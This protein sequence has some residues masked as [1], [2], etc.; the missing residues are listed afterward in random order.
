MDSKEHNP[1]QD[2][3]G[4]EQLLAR[5]EEGDANAQLSLGEKY[6]DG[7]CVLKD[8][9][10][11]MKWY[12]KAADQGDAMAQA[13]LGLM[14]VNREFETS[15]PLSDFPPEWRYRISKY[16]SWLDA[17]TSGK[18]VPFT[19][20][21]KLFV[22]AVECRTRCSFD[23]VSQGWIALSNLNSL[24]NACCEEIHCERDDLISQGEFLTDEGLEPLMDL[25]VTFSCTG[26]WKG[27]AEVLASAL[28]QPRVPMDA[29]SAVSSIPKLDS[30]A[31]STVLEL[32][33]TVERIV[34]LMESHR[35]TVNGIN[36]S[37]LPSIRNRAPD[38]IEWVDMWSEFLT[39]R[40]N[41]RY[42]DEY[43]IERSDGT[44]VEMVA[45]WESKEAY[46]EHERVVNESTR[47]EERRISDMLRPIMGGLDPYGE[48]DMER[49]HGSGE[50][51]TS[52]EYFEGWND[53]DLDN[54]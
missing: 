11:A 18:L 34:G 19:L 42:V 12:R 27:P 54:Y 13:R 7:Q 17:L 35:Q 33:E 45:V 52:E 6:Y 2:E 10:E 22:L 47:S 37:G 28:L 36:I 41:R 44:E 38:I 48:P 16:G 23:P 30:C 50:D 4:F 49:E 15:V 51:L 3:T 21:Q 8:Y 53:E 25:I 14:Y 9:K 43:V 31:V 40:N 24:I 32:L 5:A 20:K 26:V 1:R 39:L 46:D 29:L